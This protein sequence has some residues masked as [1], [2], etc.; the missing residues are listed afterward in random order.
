MGRPEVASTV[1]DLRARLDA[2]RRAGDRIAL[3]PTMG[4][5]HAGHLALVKAGE[6]TCDRVVV[7]IFVNPT[8]FAPN[9]DFSSY[10]RTFDSDLD[11]LGAAA[12]DLVYAPAPQEIYPEGDATVVTVGGPAVGLES[13]TRPHF[14]AGVATVVAKLLIQCAPDV[15]VFGEKDFQQLAVI[16]RMVRDM[17]LPVT[18]VAEPTVREADGLAMSSRNAYLGVE[19]RRRSADLY[20]AL[21]KAA[22]EIELGERESIA[23]ESARRAISDS[24]FT[25]DYVAH[26]DAATLGPAS[27]VAAGRIL[28]AAWIEGVRLI[29]NVAVGATHYPDPQELSRRASV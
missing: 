27:S 28:A 15:A 7:S 11:K 5:L 10:P 24:G 19:A 18:I 4:A 6:A 17:A 8:Q 13:V 20:A 9:E 26:R 2:W 22:T 12:V 16:R 3:V 25:V 1:A 21:R 14:F 29:D 23:I